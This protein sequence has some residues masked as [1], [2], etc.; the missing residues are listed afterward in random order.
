LLLLVLL[1]L[2]SV[3]LLAGLFVPAVERYLL[4]FLITVAGLTPGMSR[5]G[6]T[7]CRWIELCCPQLVE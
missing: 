7:R 5:R 3:S 1:L 2:L 6:V 4:N